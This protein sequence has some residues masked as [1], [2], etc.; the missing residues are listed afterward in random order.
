MAE[1]FLAGV[2]LVKA[3]APEEVSQDAPSSYTYSS[4]SAGRWAPQSHQDPCCASVLGAGVGGGGGIE[5]Q[6]R[7]PLLLG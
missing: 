1:A 3:A 5:G 6:S 4:K 7:S 2:Q